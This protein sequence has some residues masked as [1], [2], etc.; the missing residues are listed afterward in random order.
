M[1]S[2][3]PTYLMWENHAM[4]LTPR[5]IFTAIFL[6][7]ASL[8]A[9]AIYYF[10]G[11][12]GLEPCP[13]CIV[14]RY[15]FMVIG[16]IALV[17]AIHGPRGLALKA[18]AGLIALFAIVG[19]GVSMRHSY[20]Q[21]FP[22]AMESCGTDL[23]FLLNNLPLT[24][25]FPKIFAGTGSCS[26]VDWKMLGMSIPEWA[27]VWFAIFGATAAWIAWRRPK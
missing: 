17:A 22:P 24:Q 4:R 16:A 11:Q 15:C 18:Y 1:G 10:Q 27:L 8:I 6:I 20:L 13:M 2:A 14:S 5:I 12:L 3:L 26:K 23:E 7:S 21:R 25:A 9:V 19:I